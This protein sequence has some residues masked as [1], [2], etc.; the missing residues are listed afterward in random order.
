M[1]KSQPTRELAP[2]DP[3]ELVARKV[4]YSL[5]GRSSLRCSIGFRSTRAGPTA[6]NLDTGPSGNL[7]GVRRR[8]FEGACD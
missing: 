1:R 7:G 8:I 6:T 5:Q 3:V 2:S 4:S